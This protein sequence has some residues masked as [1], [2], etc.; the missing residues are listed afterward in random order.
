[1]PVL[2]GYTIDDE[3]TAEPEIGIEVTVELTSG[4]RRWC[5]FMTPTA[6]TRCG[7]FIAGTNVR[8]HFGAAHMIVVSALSPE[9]IKQALQQIDA[10]GELLASTRPLTDAS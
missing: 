6:L 2:K 5:Y 1:M 7:D 10:R 8:L 3:F 9:I 4:E